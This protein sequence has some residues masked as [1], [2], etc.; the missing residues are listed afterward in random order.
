M[1]LKVIEL[2]LEIV[3]EGMRG[4]SPEQKKLMWDW[5]IQD[6]AWWRKHFPLEVPKP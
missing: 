3:L 1:P 4:Q 5:Y 2:L 6:M